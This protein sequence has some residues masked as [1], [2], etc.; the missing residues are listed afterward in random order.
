MPVYDM[1]ARGCPQR[2]RVGWFVC[3][4]GGAG[5]RFLRGESIEERI[6]RGGR[7]GWRGVGFEAEGRC[8]SDACP[9]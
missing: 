4:F 9:T 7:F 6:R 2:G 5:S 3:C 8:I 1:M